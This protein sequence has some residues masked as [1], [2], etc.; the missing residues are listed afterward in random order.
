M[1]SLPYVTAYVDYSVLSILAETP[2]KK[3]STYKDWQA[4]QTIWNQFKKN[5]IR[6]TTCGKDTE[7]DIIFW[8]NRKGCC[9]AYA[10]MI[11]EAI[12]GFEE[13]GKVNKTEIEGYKKIIEYYEELEMLPAHIDGTCGR[14]N[15]DKHPGIATDLDKKLFSFLC[16]EVL[17]YERQ[18]DY[19]SYSSGHCQEEDRNILKSCLKKLHL[20]LT[21]SQWSKIGQIDY[22]LNWDILT[23][24]LAGY[25]IE[26]IFEGNE[27][28]S[29]RNLFGLLNRAIGFSKKSCRELPLNDSHIDFVIETVMEK[30]SYREE[31]RDARHICNCASHNIG[32]FMTADYSL[33]ERFNQGKQLLQKHPEFS[34]INLKLL[35][36]SEFEVSI[37]SSRF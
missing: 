19:S 30:Y 35:S 18:T 16:D 8:L 29:N 36:P 22:Q 14:H 31:K 33:I 24:V 17:C 15:T 27:G 12:E 37:L 6:L 32:F 7:V 9:V 26:P 11:F 28:E 1:I 13:W 2:F 23:S 20:W 3:D 25:F 21:H 34:S 10:D 5:L 4:I